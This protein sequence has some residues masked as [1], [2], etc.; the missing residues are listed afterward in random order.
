MLYELREIN[1]L[2]VVKNWTGH[3]G[4]VKVRVKFHLG[5][6]KQQQRLTSNVVENYKNA[7]IRG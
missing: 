4:S 6:V 1:N 5:R 7:K 2:L 3:F